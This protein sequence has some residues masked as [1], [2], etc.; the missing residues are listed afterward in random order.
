[1]RSF[2]DRCLYA[3]LRNLRESGG[4][5]VASI[6]WHMRVKTSLSFC[7]PRQ[8]VMFND[9]MD[10]TVKQTDELRFS[11]E[12]SAVSEIVIAKPSQ[13]MISLVM[14]QEAFIYVQLSSL[15]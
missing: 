3:C 1:M 2:C 9:F 12:L 6:Q 15:I 7:F 8:A 11:L 14:F 5:K 4:L 13:T 10:G